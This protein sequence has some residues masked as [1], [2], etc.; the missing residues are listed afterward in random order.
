MPKSRLRSAKED[1]LTEV[2]SQL[3][4]T[5]CRDLL[6]NLVVRLPLYAGLRTG[7]VR[8]T[9]RSEAGRLAAAIST[10][11]LAIAFGLTVI[12]RR[13]RNVRMIIMKRSRLHWVG[14][15]LGLVSVTGYTIT[16]LFLGFGTIMGGDE[17]GI[18]LWLLIP[19][20]LISMILSW[21]W[22]LTDAQRLFA[23]LTLPFLLFMLFIP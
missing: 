6:D 13:K 15:I 18:I 5:V 21:K 9:R 7:E 3:L 23:Q 20:V 4:L 19:L 22:L 12:L 8:L 16:L 2:E 11:G 1:V 17:S 10:T 14:L